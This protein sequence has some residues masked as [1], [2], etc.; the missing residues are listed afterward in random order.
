MLYK[1]LVPNWLCRPHVNFHIVKSNTLNVN[2]SPCIKNALL[3]R[4][5][6]FTIF[7]GFKF[8]ALHSSNDNAIVKNYMSI[9][10]FLTYEKLHE[11]GE[12]TL[13]LI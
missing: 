8:R 2:D 9:V 3:L 4:R 5:H 6:N 10:G 11:L 7:Y 12:A 1:H 13:A